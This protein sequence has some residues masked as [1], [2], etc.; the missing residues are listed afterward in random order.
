MSGRLSLNPIK[1]LD[2]LGLLMILFAG[3]GW[4]KPVPVNPYYYKN[5]RRDMAL[6]GLAGPAANFAT[7]FVIGRVGMFLLANPAFAGLE[8]FVFYGAYINIILGFFNL[9]PIPPLDGS[10]I[11]AYFIPDRFLNTYWKLEKYG[12]L[13]VFLLVFIFGRVLWGVL[14]PLVN[15]ML[16]I[17]GIPV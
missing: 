4:A 12:I 9:V 11:I 6:V 15:L 10:K 17:A 8:T 16:G 1:H 5:P 14:T 7:A 2:I 13:L 3:I